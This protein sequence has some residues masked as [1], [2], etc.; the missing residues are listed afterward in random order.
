MNK[1]WIAFLLAS[2]A[3]SKLYAIEL[4]VLTENMPPYNYEEELSHKATGF[5]VEIV[6]ELLSRSGIGLAGDAILVYPWSRAYKMVQI[7]KNVVLLSMTKTE[8]RESLFKWVGPLAPRT[9]W[10]WKLKERKDIIVNS[11]EEA[12]KYSVGGVFEFASSQYLQE[13]GFKVE[14][15]SKI[16]QNWRKLFRGRIDMVSG[17]ELEAAYN[18]KKKGKNFNLLEKLIK[19]DDRYNYYLAIN[20][21]TSDEIVNQLQEAL[22]AMK[23]DGSYEVIRQKYLK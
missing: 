5:S 7:E 23:T 12:K 6:K 15:T 19:I 10:L 20:K 21:Q 4:K 8:E 14:M 11:F 13:Q 9:I 18:M 16:E 2:F 3:V 22:E 1:L 17:L